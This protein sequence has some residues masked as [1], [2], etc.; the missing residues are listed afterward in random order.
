MD[1]EE[2]RSL[3]RALERICAFSAEVRP[4]ALPISMR[5][6]SACLRSGIGNESCGPAKVEGGSLDRWDEVSFAI[7]VNPF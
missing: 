4:L 2:E 6:A 7:A 1:R 3:A 5:A